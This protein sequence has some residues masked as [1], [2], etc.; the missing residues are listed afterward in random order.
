MQILIFWTPPA[1]ESEFFW[2]KIQKWWKKLFSHVGLKAHTRFRFEQKKTLILSWD[3]LWR[4]GERKLHQKKWKPEVNSLDA[5]VTFFNERRKTLI[6]NWVLQWT[7][8]KC[9]GTLGRSK[10]FLQ[11]RSRQSASCEILNTLNTRSIVFQQSVAGLA[12]GAQE[13]HRFR[14]GDMTTVLPAWIW[15]WRIPSGLDISEFA[16]SQRRCWKNENSHPHYWREADF[17]VHGA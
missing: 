10:L 9:N 15:R 13:N 6:L 16:F 12:P 7:I 8:K 17:F 2:L 4:I 14:G 3:W 11:R 5:V 1:R